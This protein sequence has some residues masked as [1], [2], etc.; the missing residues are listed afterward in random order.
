[1]Q[2]LQTLLI[3][4]IPFLL[5]IGVV[6]TVH[7]LGHFLAA[8]ALGT[9]VDRFSIG[10]GRTLASWTDKAGVEW[11]IGA[12]PIGG[13]VRFAGDDNAASIPDADDLAAMRRKLTAEGRTGEIDSYFHFKPIWQRAIIVAAGPL[14]NFLLAIAIFATLLMALGQ[15]IGSTRID[16]VAPGSAAEAAGFR[17]GDVI[18]S[19]EGREVESFDQV[20]DK[21][22]LSSGTPLDF[23]VRRGDQEVS[24]VATPQRGPI[25]DP[26]GRTHMLGKL[27]L[28]HRQQPGDVT[29]RRYNLPEAIVGGVEKTASTIGTTLTYIG[30]IIGGRENADQLAGPL[31]MAQLSGDLTKQVKDASPGAGAF[32]VNLGITL[33]HLI[34]VISVSIGFINL[35][36]VPV[37]DGGHLM[38][39]AYEAVARRP[40][41]A[42]VQAAGYRVGLALVLS[43]MLFATWNDLQRLRVFNL[44]GG[45]FS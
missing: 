12:L 1:M 24:I 35:L 39:Y 37:L 32:M 14:A 7:E 11:R 25:K 29:I 33:F 20:S 17:K 13:Y 30:R 6:I 28:E 18:L 9:K 43:L 23:V 3:Y 40:L 19:M 45:L 42:K 26:M 16:G 10:F 38:F 4:A 21:V 36:P 27:G 41:A 34:G 44:F 8:R 5:V 15:P 22:M 31:G 2:A